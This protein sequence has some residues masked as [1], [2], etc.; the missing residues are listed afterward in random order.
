MTAT[1]LRVLPVPD[2]DPPP[3]PS[4]GPDRGR[5]AHLRAQADPAQGV[6]SLVLTNRQ[7]GG[8]HDDLDDAPAGPRPTATRDLPVAAE[9]GRRLVQVLI[10]VMSGQRPPTQLLRWTSAE[11]YD[12]VLT[13]TLPR[14]RPGRHPTRRRPRVSSV[15]VCEPLDGVAELSAFVRGQYRV[16]ALAL[17]LEGQDGRWLVTALETG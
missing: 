6:L 5:S 11:V 2:T 9:W 15:R 10:E 14:P 4:D 3:E 1:A 8:A 16:Q 7:S 17:R 12:A 13:Q